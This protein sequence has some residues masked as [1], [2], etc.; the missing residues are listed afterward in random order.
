MAEIVGQLQKALGKGKKKIF[1][2]TV[3]V[4]DGDTVDTGLSSVDV[5]IL[6][7]TNAAHIAAATS[8]EWFY[9]SISAVINEFTFTALGLPVWCSSWTHMCCD[10][11]T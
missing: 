3:S 9:C 2:G 11:N 1:A 10:L 7:T 5:V 6:T 4:A 8:L